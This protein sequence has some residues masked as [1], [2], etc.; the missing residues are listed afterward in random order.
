MLFPTLNHSHQKG[1]SGQSYFQHFVNNELKCIYHPINQ[2]NDFGIDGYIE[3]VIDRCVTGKLIGVQI[4][5]GNSFFRSKTDYGF[6]FIGDNKHLNYYLNSQAPIFILIMDEDFVNNHWVEFDLSK[7]MSTTSSNWWI[8]VPEN[9]RLETN[10]SK[11]IFASTAPVIDFTA[12]IQANFAM[13]FIVSNSDLRAIAIPK[14]EILAMS[15]DYLSGFIK[16]L[17]ANRK[18]LL[19]SRSTLNIFFPDYDSDPREIIQIPEIMLW[20]KRS[21]EIG[22]PWFY[23]LDT[24]HRSSGL[25]LLIHSYCM[26]IDISQ[27]TTRYRVKYNKQDLTRFVEKNFTNLNV[28]TDSNNIS[29]D[30]NK[31]VSSGIVRF[32]EKCLL[33]EVSK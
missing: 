11:A 17:S 9:N 1:S 19:E 21:I 4:K 27:E 7:T 2:E 14:D 24:R 8:E 26:P 3:L 20:L 5:H 13:N 22:F 29:L 28:F 16:R 18:L 12:Q 33:P 30:I 23:Y 31:E 10:F 32:L 15:F 25:M 6:K